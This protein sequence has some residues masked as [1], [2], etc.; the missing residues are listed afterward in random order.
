MIKYIRIKKTIACFFLSLLMIETLFPVCAWALTSGPAQPESKQF[1]TAGT[2]D[3]VDLFSGAFKYDVPI[4]D[5]DGYPIN[6][7]YQSGTSMDDEASWVGLGWNL[8]VGAINRQL[9]GLPD[10]FKGDSVITEHKIKPKITFGGRGTIKTEIKG[11][12]IGKLSGS[13]SIGIFSDNYTGIGA[14]VGA[15]AG[16]SFSI[17]N[18]GVLTGGLGLGVNSNTSNGVSLTPSV[19][20]SLSE[21]IREVNTTS[22]SLSA[23]LGYN[24]RQGLKD[25]TLSQSFGL[26]GQDDYGKGD[27]G[28]ET[29]GS[30]YSYNTPGFYPQASIAY[31][32]S[33]ETYSIDVGG[34]AFAVFVGGGLTGYYSKREVNKETNTNPAYGFMYAEKG[35]GQQNAMMDFMREKDNPVITS[36]PNL[37]VPIATPDVFSYSSQA[38][39]GQFRLYRGSSSVLFDARA[40]DVSNNRTIGLDLGFGAYFHGGVTFYQQDVTTKTGK[41]VKENN[42]LPMADYP[43]DISKLN[44]EAVYF[45]R[46][47]EKNLGDEDFINRVKGEKVVSVPINERSSLAALEDKDGVNPAT[48]PYKKT[49][50]EIKRS[51]ISWL[52]AEEADKGGALDKYI[53]PVAFKDSATFSPDPCRVTSTTNHPRVGYNGRKGHHLS[54]LT[55]TGDDGKRMV[56]GLP[57]YNL[58]QEEFSFAVNPA[59]ADVSKNLVGM[60]VVNGKVIPYAGSTDEYYH[61]EIQPAY[62]TSYLL[63]GIL[64]PDYVD[65]TG[66]GISDDDPG[67]AIKFNYAKVN[68]NYQ[69]RSPYDSSKA[70]YNKGLL[71]DSKDDKGSFVYGEKE[72]WYIQ[73]IETKTKVIYFITE[74]REDALGVLDF[75]GGRNTAVKQK[76]LKEIRLFSRSDLQHPI[77]TVFFK[78]DYTLCPGVPNQLKPGAGKLTLK[79]VYFQYGNSDKGKNHPY[80]FD[81]TNN[82]GYAYLSADRWGT[83]KPVGNNLAPNSPLRNDEFPYSIQNKAVADASAGKWQLNKISLPTGGE[84]NVDYESGDYAYVQDK[85]AMEMVAIKNLIKADGAITNDL[86]EARGFR[87]KIPIKLT[88]SESEQTRSFARHYLN[89]SGMFYGKLAV[90]VTDKVDNTDDSR[91]EF[92]PCYA[93]VVQAKQSENDNDYVDVVFEEISSGGIASNPFAFAALQKMRMEYP[94]YAYPGYENRITSEKP[95]AAALG[96]LVNSIGNLGELRESFYQRAKRKKFASIVKLD[97]SF[98]RIVKVNGKKMGGGARVKKV[99]ISDKWNSMAG[100]INPD[101]SYG[102][103]Y[104][105]VKKENRNGSGE[106]EISSGVASYEPGIGSDENP[107]RMPVPYTEEMRGTMNN[108]FYLEEPFG[109]SLYPAAQV[110][111]SMI[112]V[113]DLNE[114]GNTD[115]NAK[116][117]WTVHEFYTAKEFPVQV[118]YE[119]KP[120]TQNYQPPGWHNFVGG[121]VVHELVMSQ[122]YVVMLNDMHGKA[123]A[124]RIFNQSGSEISSTVYHYNAEQ[125]DAGKYRLRNKVT[126]TDEEGFLGKDRVIGRDLEMFV[127]MREQETTNVG[128]SIQV[129]A[130]VIPF[131]FGFPLPI[132][133]WP[134]RENDEYRLFRSSCVL[135]TVQ[136]SGILDKVV[137]TVN[138]SS[139]TSSN[140]VYDMYTGEPVVTQTTNE[141]DDPVYTTSMPAYWAYGQMGGAYKNLNTILEGFT[142]S[143]AGVVN[144]AFANFLTAGDELVNLSTTGNPEK[145]W[146]VHSETSN[147]NN[148][149]LRVINATGQLRPC[150]GLKVKVIRSGYRNQLTSSTASIVSLKTPLFG[151][152]LTMLK[153]PDASSYK[154][155]DAK[156]TL[157]DEKWGMPVPCTTCPPGYTLTA[158]GQRCVAAATENLSNDLIIGVGD[159]DENKAYGL[160][161]AF[162]YNESGVLVGTVKNAFWGGNCGSQPSFAKEAIPNEYLSRIVPNDTARAAA[163][164]ESGLAAASRPATEGYCGRLVEEGIWLKGANTVEYNNTWMGIETCVTFPTSGEYSIGYGVDDHIR[165]Y[166]DGVLWKSDVNLD[167]TAYRRWWVYTK[168]VTAGSHT[169]KIEKLNAGG[170]AAVAL[171]IY[172]G[173]ASSLMSADRNYVTNNRIFYTSQLID[174]PVQT[175]ILYRVF[176]SRYRYTCAVGE[177]DVCATPCNCGS[178][179]AAGQVNPYVSGFLGNWRPSETKVYQVSRKDEAHLNSNKGIDVRNSG[180]Y[181]SFSPFWLFNS[182]TSWY[183]NTSASWITTQTVTLYDDQGQELENRNVLNKYSGAL[184]GYRNLLPTAVASNAMQREVFYDGFDDYN[185]R[186]VCY[187]NNICT[188]DS[189]NIYKSLGSN[190]AQRI[191]N[192]DAH[193]GN[194]SLKMTAP[195]TISTIAHGKTHKSEDYLDRSA[196]GEYVKKLLPDLYPRG[197]S[198]RADAKYIFSVWVKDGQPANDNTAITVKVNGVGID[199]KRKANVE[200]WGLVEGVIDLP[201]I[202][203]GSK[204]VTLNI[205]GASNILIDDLRIFPVEALVK[206]YAYDDKLLKVMAVLDENNFATFYEY[207]EEGNL[208]RVKKETERGIMTIQES[209][210]SYRKRSN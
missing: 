78:Y 79:R 210:S 189:F 188:P 104:S 21:K 16:L 89:E 185:F 113:K 48:I 184:Y 41:W 102:Q 173:S 117:G 146:V 91:Y 95:V 96:A 151:S 198:P 125:I 29:A 72:L 165:I 193:T 51:P 55:V 171:E 24:T 9:R 207:D 116:T 84:I 111:Y 49:K 44:E 35:T 87:I 136:Y 58:K 153:V 94:R 4:M 103:E 192:A 120:K 186:N 208:A 34:T 124:E 139:V 197:F 137:K 109:E 196:N 82:Q 134:K 105:Y 33:N 86:L 157:F 47:G 195:I 10:D 121:M 85:K 143:P 133:H 174:Q 166:I 175:Y 142:T 92:I 123:K 68:G 63:T 204:N 107:L 15:N 170:A 194:Y 57:V 93:R 43:A 141:F 147:N 27:A 14:E 99:R 13:L 70:T 145:L 83:Y 32:S 167:P 3:M 156:A 31:K 30:T 80:I 18:S 40:E 37:A 162:F 77:K 114:A 205:S 176:G 128:T 50:R 160:D 169:I 144:S 200:G 140:L 179:S 38:G 138:G 2:S 152:N 119:K 90:N 129:G 131:F 127:D 118:D 23:S 76:R 45:K 1:V 75:K 46:T 199:L 164:K 209:R 66:D 122:G 97:K 126:V 112:T 25:I 62:A 59:T 106:V 101:A 191:N 115:T 6:L 190:Y 206:S 69:W 100:A 201:T 81:Y 135:K 187:T 60:D 64:S 182:N 155:L 130:D 17:A 154:V 149:E 74:D 71:A 56:Y 22:M 7:N 98:C 161:G 19:S 8:N 54:E 163:R 158:D 172:K 177:L 178:I 11:L 168:T 20:L 148:K 181:L 202:L 61:H 67:T 150:T 36:L 52:T 28:W 39:S 183:P 73:S 42:F 203:A 65:L 132:P 108:Y 110:G 26:Y 88:G 180:H 53:T 12:N 5:I 159:L